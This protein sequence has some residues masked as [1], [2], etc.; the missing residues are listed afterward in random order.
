M[1]NLQ[2]S[3]NTLPDAIHFLETHLAQRTETI[4]VP[5]WRDCSDVL[6]S[7]HNQQAL[8]V[9]YAGRQF[10]ADRQEF[11]LGGHKSELGHLHVIFRKEGQV[12]RLA[13][14]MQCR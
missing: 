9:R 13:E 10:P 11:T 4:G 2:N 6:R 7:Y 8:S 5:G 3:F 14:L 12:W 1:A